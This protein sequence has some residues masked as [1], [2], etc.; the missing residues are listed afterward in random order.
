MHVVVHVLSRPFLNP[1][2]HS[3]LLLLLCLRY[4]SVG[5][6]TERRAVRKEE[7]VPGGGGTAAHQGLPSLQ[8]QVIHTYTCSV[9][10]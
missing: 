3:R 10:R 5:C 2:L 9:D 8:R 7:V 6:P 4:L 1:R